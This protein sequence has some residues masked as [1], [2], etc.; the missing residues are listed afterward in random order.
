M[1][2][3]STYELVQDGLRKLKTDHSA[4]E[5]TKLGILRAG[6]TGIVLEE[7]GEQI[8][9]GKCARQTYLRL[10]GIDA[11]EDD[12]SRE[13][14]FAAGRTNED[15]WTDLF[16]KAGIPAAQIKREEEIPISWKTKSGRTVSGRPDI[17]LLDEKGKPERVIELKLVSS[18]WTGRDVAIGRKP[19]KD[20]PA[21][22]AAAPKA[23]HLMQAAHYS[24]QLDAPA[25]IWY[26]CRADFH[27]PFGNFWPALGEAGSEY[28]EYKD[29]KPLKMKPFIVGFETEWRGGDM[30]Y[31]SI[32]AGTPGHW[33]KSI[34]TK[35][36]IADYFE[37][38]DSVALH[39]FMP[40]RPVN[41]TATGSAASYSICQYCPLEQVCDKRENGG[42]DKWVEEVVKWSGQLPSV[43]SLAL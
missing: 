1:S 38:V 28:F 7:G 40:P 30:Y 14:M 2:L 43:G 32:G 25:E 12:P 42:L 41:L 15:S 20:N 3:K 26:T 16:L 5:K 4:L 34:V 29:S 39:Q 36:G 22:Q 10:I 13:F 18:L 17:V 31:R 37:L 24:W 33:V 21:G 35:Q 23:M 9:V 11:G 19:T 27:L 6:N 8:V